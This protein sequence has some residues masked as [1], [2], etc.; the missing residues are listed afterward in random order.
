MAAVDQVSA[1]PMWTRTPYLARAWSWKRCARWRGASEK[2]RVAPRSAGPRASPRCTYT[3][4]LD[5]LCGG[6]TFS[7]PEHA[8]DRAGTAAAALR[9]FD[10]G[11]DGIHACAPLRAAHPVGN[12]EPETGRAYVRQGYAEWTRVERDAFSGT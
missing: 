11:T 9:A 10:V 2:T 3:A 8:L 6:A 1:I 5:R 7:Q 12:D 4:E